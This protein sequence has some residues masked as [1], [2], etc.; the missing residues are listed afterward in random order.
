MSGI[1]ELWAG[2]AGVI[3]LV[4]MVALGVRVY[5]AAALT[6]FLGLLVVLLL[7][8]RLL[9]VPLITFA[10]AAILTGSTRLQ[11]APSLKL[12]SSLAGVLQGMLVLFVILFQGVREVFFPKALS[13]DDEAI[14]DSVPSASSVVGQKR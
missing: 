6:G 2:I 7:S 11:I 9:W 12:D 5:V 10:F 8:I 1:S 13:G 14:E 4:T 3:L